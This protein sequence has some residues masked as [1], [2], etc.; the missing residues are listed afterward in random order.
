MARS[1]LSPHE[2]PI[3]G[4]DR[5][6]ERVFPKVEVKF[7]RNLLIWAF[8]ETIFVFYNIRYEPHQVSLGYW[9]KVSYDLNRLVE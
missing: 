2:A 1:L 7:N 9:N 5:C 3:L 6:S 4:V 8:V